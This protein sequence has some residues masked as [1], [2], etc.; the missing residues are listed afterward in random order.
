[1]ADANYDIHI[2]PQRARNRKPVFVISTERFCELHKQNHLLWHHAISA[3][4]R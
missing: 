1:M 2:K 4:E 3:L